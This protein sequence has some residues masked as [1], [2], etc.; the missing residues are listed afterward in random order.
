VLDQVALF[1]EANS[2]AVFLIVIVGS[3]ALLFALLL[4][5]Q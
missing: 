4:R 2:L 5:C 1:V 3:G